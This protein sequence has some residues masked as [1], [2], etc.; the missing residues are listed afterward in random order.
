MAVIQSVVDNADGTVTV[1]LSSGSHTQLYTAD[2]TSLFITPSA[3]AWTSR[4]SAITGAGSA[5]FSITPGMHWLS[6]IDTGTPLPPVPTPFWNTSGTTD[7]FD[8][9]LVAVQGVIQTLN[10]ADIG[11]NVVLRKFPVSFDSDTRPIAVVFPVRET[12]DPQAGVN[13]RDDVGYGVGVST[14]YAGNHDASDTTIAA[15]LL[16]R[17]RIASAF[18]NQRLA[19]VPSV[20]RCYVDPGAVYDLDGWNKQLD[21]GSLIIRCISREARGLT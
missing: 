11:S 8:Q 5:T 7:I 21:A 4:G 9:C 17:K 2:T 13:S 12:M 18:R 16:A 1:T 20:W 15:Q 6:A 10:I 19:G 3:T 14:F